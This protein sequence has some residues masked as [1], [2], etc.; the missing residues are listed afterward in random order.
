[1]WLRRRRGKGRDQLVGQARE[2]QRKAAGSLHALAD[3]FQ[4][5]SEKTDGSGVAPELARQASDRLRGVASWFEDRE[6]GRLLDDVRGFA[7][8]KPGVFLAGA[9]VAGALVGRLTRGAVQSDGESDGEADGSGG[10]Y[11]RG[12]V[13]RQPDRAVPRP[14]RAVPPSP[15]GAGGV[16]PPPPPTPYPSGPPAT[17]MP[18]APGYSMPPEPSRAY[19]SPGSGPVR[20]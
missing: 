4:E 7:R 13:P 2:G 10:A 6:P 3:Q 14:D 8:R 18:P 20:P 9:V 17:P 15:T 1:V 11:A 19:P 16:V 12:D 5:M